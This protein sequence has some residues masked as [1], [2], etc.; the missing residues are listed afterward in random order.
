MRRGRGRESFRI[1]EP[2]PV[3]VGEDEVEVEGVSPGLLY[4]A[5]L[6]SFL[7][8][9]LPIMRVK[10]G[11]RCLAVWKLEG[12]G[13]WCGKDDDCLLV[14]E[15]WDVCHS[16]SWRWALMHPPAPHLS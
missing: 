16:L 10:R 5:F 6:V 15:F 7:L 3:G 13:F 12:C 4:E 11:R 14:C 9:C 2:G 8:V 1:E